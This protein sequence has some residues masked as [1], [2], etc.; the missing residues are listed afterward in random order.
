[1]MSISLGVS[2][3]DLWS[4]EVQNPRLNVNM[5]EPP[6]PG[7]PRL[8]WQGL[9][10]EGLSVAVTTATKRNR[11]AARGTTPEVCLQIRPL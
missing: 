8:G 7:Q 10:I 2:T 5:S 11:D 3:E 6:P 9:E 1:M 4:V